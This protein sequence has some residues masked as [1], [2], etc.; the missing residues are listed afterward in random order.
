MRRAALTAAYENP[1]TR[2][3]VAPLVAGKDLSKLT[4]DALSSTFIGASEIVRRSNNA[5]TLPTFDGSKSAATVRQSISEIN[6]R[7]SEFWKRS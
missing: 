5:Q 6:R 3:A 4:C 2:D 1:K 7:N